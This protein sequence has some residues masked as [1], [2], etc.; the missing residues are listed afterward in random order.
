MVFVDDNDLHSLFQINRYAAS[1]LNDKN[2]W[3]KRILYYYNLK[4]SQVNPESPIPKGWSPQ[5]FRALMVGFS[6]PSSVIKARDHLTP[7]QHYYLVKAHFDDPINQSLRLSVD[8]GIDRLIQIR[9]LRPGLEKYL[10]LSYCLEKA[11]EEGNEDLI[12]YYLKQLLVSNQH[13]NYPVIVKIA[14]HNHHQEKLPA[15]FD[16]FEKSPNKTNVDQSSFFRILRE[17]YW[18][19]TFSV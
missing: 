1:F 8:D 19:G 11:F 16:S 14:Y 4:I 12:E 9:K 18:S 10:G 15:L 13:V 5:V 17:E 3:C 7:S 2:F 6:Y